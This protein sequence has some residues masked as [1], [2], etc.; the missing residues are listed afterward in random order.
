MHFVFKYENRRVKLTEIVL[1]RGDVGE[2]GESW[3]G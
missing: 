3:R 1:R 2:E